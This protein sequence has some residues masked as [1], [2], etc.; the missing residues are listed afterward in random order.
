MAGL[1]PAI[2]VVKPPKNRGLSGSQTTWMAGTSPVMTK[3][4]V[5]FVQPRF[6]DK[7]FRSRCRKT[8]LTATIR[9]NEC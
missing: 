4:A 9:S 8:W 1:V 2:H 6:S 5:L 7:V 3:R